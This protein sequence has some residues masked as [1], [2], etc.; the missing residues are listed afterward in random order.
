METELETARRELEALRSSQAV[1]ESELEAWTRQLQASQSQVEQKVQM[2][3]EALSAGANRLENAEHEA[4][5]S[6]IR[7]NEMEA[8]LTQMRQAHTHL[9]QEL[10]AAKRGR[11]AYEE[12]AAIEKSRLEARAQELQTAQVQ[13]DEQIKKLQES[14]ATETQRREAIKQRAAEHARCRGELEAALAQN[15]QTEMALQREMVASDNAKR[16]GELEAELRKTT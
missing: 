9:R 5:E 14:L 15:E 8:E 3:T 12:S 13:T 7:R 10:E 1:R 2:L 4:G 16:R 11:M 6:A